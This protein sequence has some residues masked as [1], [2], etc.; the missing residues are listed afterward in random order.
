MG[1][2]SNFN[3]ESYQQTD[4]AA[5]AKRGSDIQ[6]VSITDLLSEGPIEGLVNGEASVYLAGDQLSDSGR[7][8]KES[9]LGELTGEPKTITFSA[10]SSENQPVTASMKDAAGNTAYYN[11]LEET[12][13]DDYRYR[14]IT[15]HKVDIRKIKI[16]SFQK[17]RNQ[18][19]VLPTT[20]G[21][22]FICS[23]AT[24]SPFAETAN[25]PQSIKPAAG[26]GNP[27]LSNLKP[28][29]RLKLPNGQELYGNI[30]SLHGE[31]FNTEQTSG[32]A[33]RAV[34][35]PYFAV[36]TALTNADIFVAGQNEVY[37]ELYIDRILK[38][39][40]RTVNSNNV[41][42]IPKNSASLAVTDKEF[43]LSGEQ[44]K[45]GSEQTGV[46][47]SGGMKYPG[48]SVE[49]RIGERTQQPFHQLSGVG[50]A[51]FPVTL[52]GSQME[53]FDTTNTYISTIPAGYPDV[54]PL[55]TGMVQKNII[56]SQS[57]TSAQINEIDRVKIQFE[58]PQGHYAMHEEGDEFASGAA[59][60]IE[61]QGSES[62]GANPTDWTDIA[63]GA[64]KY[65]KWFGLQKTAIAYTV[66]IPVTTHLN[67]ADMRLQITRLTPDGT[68][69]SNNHLGQLNSNGYIV[70]RST[71]DISMVVDTLKINQVVATIDEKLEHPFS[72]MA[73]V[74]FSSKSFPN[75]PK[76]A[77]L[78]RGL[79]V[80][81]PSNYTP[82]HKSSTG[83]ATYTG[84]WNG[85]FSD[86]GTSNSSGLDIDT[87]YTD[88][89][90]WVFYDILINNR[91]GLG[92]YLQQNEIN[93]FQ[94]YK[95]AKYC[96][97][98]VPT[99]NGGTEPRFTMNLYLTKATEAYKV[100]KDMATTFRGILYWL[101]G[102]MV[103]VHD[104]PSTPIYNFSES[105]ILEGTL[106]TQNT[107]S[108]SRANQYTVIWNNPLAAY[109]QEP[110]VIEDRKNI[111]ETGKIIPQKAVAFGCTSEG[112]AIRY[113][114]WKAWTAIN[115]TEIVGFKT[116]INAAFLTPGDVINVQDKAST[117]ISFS[118]RITAS[119][120]SAITLDRNVS[121][122]S[123]QAQIDGG[124]AE[125]FSFQGG[126][127]F[128]Y[129]LSLL[130]EK[131]GVFL[132][133]DTPVNVTHSGT[134]H[135]YNR[136]DEVQYGKIAGTSTLL[137]GTNDS[138]EQVLKNIS[139]I[140]DDDGNDILVDFR[141]STTIENKSF[142]ASAVSIVNGVTQIAISSAFSGT[143]PANTVWAIKEQYRG[144]N[145]VA[146]YK[147]YKILGI[148]E[149]KDNNFEI[150]AVEFYNSKF[151]AID[152]DFR[153]AILDPIKPPEP[154]YVPPPS[155][156]YVFEVP[157]H[158]QQFQELQVMWETP[159][160]ADN[161]EYEHVSAFAL[162]VEPRLPDG[163]DL[164]NITN[165][166]HRIEL[167]SGVPDGIYNFGIQTLTK[168][169][170]RSEIRWQAIEVKDKFKIACNRTTEGVPLGIRAN[171]MMSEDTDTW[172]IDIN[173]WALQ[174]PGAPGT[175]VNNTAQ[176]DTDN[177][178]QSLTA[179]GD[180]E[181]GF[182]YF[183]ADDTTDHFKLVR[184][185]AATF[186]N[187]RQVYWRDLTQFT[188]NSENDWTD[189]TNNADA[190]VTVATRSNKVVKS[191][192]T[193]AFLSRF[194]VGDIIR[195]KYAANKYVGAK[196]AFIQS[197]DVLYVDR[198][199]NHT[200]STITS[201]DEAKAIARTALRPDTANDA[202]IAGII[203]SGSN[204]T[205]VPMNWVEDKTL[206]GL[207]ALIVDANVVALNYNDS[208]VLQNNVA[209]TITADATAYSAPEFKVTGGGFSG[210]SGSADGSFSTSGVSGIT[211]TKQIHDGSA[212]IAYNS[213]AALEFTVQVRESADQ[214]FAKTKTFRIIKA[215]DGSI[216]LDGKTVQLVSDDY[217]IIYDEEG[218]NPS[219]TSSGS[220]NIVV[221]ATANNFT[222][223]LYRFTFDGGTP[224]AWT[225]T[226]GTSAATFTYA[227]GSIP[228]TYN[229]ANWPKVLKVEVG[230]KPGSYSSGDAPASVE[231]T[232]S[233]AF[234]GVKTGAGGVAFVNSNHAHTYVTPSTG[235][236]TGI[237][238][239]GTTLE[240]IVGG[241][242]Y[243]YIGGA[244][245]HGYNNPSGSL[246]NKQ[247]YLGNPTVTGSDLTIGTPTGV[248]S[249]VVTIGNHTGTADTDDTEV[250]TWTAHYKQAGVAKTITTT[251]TL[252]KSKT[253]DDGDPGVDGAIA[254]LAVSSPAVTYSYDGTNWDPSVSSSTVTVNTTG[255]T[256]VGYSWSGAG[257]GTGAVR[258]IS[259]S[260]NI[261]EGSIPGAQTTSVTVTGTKSDGTTNFSQAL[262]TTI[263]VAKGSV[264]P[265]GDDAPRVVTG[266]IYW[267]G[268]AGTTPTNS[269]RPGTTTYDF[270]ATLADTTFTPALAAGSNNS[271]NWSISPP[272]ASSTRQT[273]FYAPFTATENLSNGN[274]TGSG[275]V[276]FGEVA[277][278]I[279]FTGVVTFNGTSGDAGSTI[280]DA[281][282]TTHNLTQIS[283]SNV[284]TGIIKSAGTP[285]GTVDGSDFLTNGAH[286][287]INLTSGG[288][289]SKHF[290]IEDDGEL[291][292]R[293]STG[294]GT[295]QGTIKLDSTNQRITITDE[296]VDRVIIGKLTT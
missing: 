221:T 273:V 258:T 295:G 128:A 262:S 23:V 16:E 171:T 4:P 182:I 161:S 47:P 164:I 259:F 51:S 103:P 188:A 269:D 139:N 160:N 149:D 127:D 86:E 238:I 81:V 104:A 143:I 28:I 111:I 122:I 2:L 173:D 219:Y 10:A 200:A 140:Q 89:P 123:S 61:L 253:G 169:G 287:Y 110:I 264:G 9:R 186:E 155:A 115:Q 126:S 25:L 40:I 168:N 145:T 113:G 217:S 5:A 70:L 172:S 167:F 66:E 112:Q 27:T 293:A 118:G 195:I 187:T 151:D 237:S 18:S 105:N 135:T 271:T 72:A 131:R 229:K 79:K 99:R 210:V 156:V 95:I 134:T 205:H 202:V 224:G 133:Q 263:S 62:G 249:N 73:S 183:D 38:V 232:D 56:F 294:T 48:S 251:Q 12:F 71:E 201:V 137:V 22:T 76:R 158:K 290:R 213:G 270:T 108:K 180:G 74:R 280:T 69:N 177:R 60:S 68:S 226:S 212:S 240:L 228:S 15:V 215:K 185:S 7:V 281:N 250:I 256:S 247:W 243:T 63:G 35:R 36:H 286:M 214:T 285:T 85:E 75:P 29:A 235:V 266:Y 26:A 218:D 94:L 296:N 46:N 33:K 179:L 277:E 236:A 194:Q 261:A 78:A 239:D 165:P 289:A 197:D 31:N 8:L 291:E 50:V 267:I 121:N 125:S 65:Q 54:D 96:D 52:T 21:N 100:L 132:N 231:A 87:Y 14:F 222:D 153:V 129:T 174:S 11:D 203:R 189:C 32:S 92:D 84:I 254:T 204:Y 42:Y 82:R 64:F 211:L 242:V 20:I 283:G 178:T 37:G 176:S 102:E 199:L 207:R 288:I 227:S 234:V 59:V 107:G 53:P 257:S 88:N 119:S 209:I 225:D 83:V 175:K 166:A 159:L 252:S 272:A 192:G 17:I 117:G 114:R 106:N 268:S 233:I 130:V 208:E 152:K 147:E 13:S 77:Y 93:K 144:R 163:T 124:N 34:F 116:S 45:K 138:D 246:Q 279:N 80:K 198:R 142:N 284:T 265:Q 109:K 292:I 230:E 157:K 245:A 282:G 43:T 141:N 190:R 101:D 67:I 58:F 206:T 276:T 148:K 220:N 216:G 162:H 91:Y 57:F 260:G 41:I 244:G 55:P 248:S 1:F 241:V 97:E 193:T 90:A 223:P 120:G 30:L 278:G 24:S 196:V 191:E 275:G 6:E 146:S 184:P 170:K 274:Q 44:I 98:L 181:K 136:G 39:D 150:T 19:G 154:D 3:I 49:F 255:L